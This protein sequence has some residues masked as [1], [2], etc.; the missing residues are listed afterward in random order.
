MDKACLVLLK[1]P[2]L[3]HDHSGG[4][5]YRCVFWSRSRVLPAEKSPK[6]SLLTIKLRFVGH[7]DVFGIKTGIFLEVPSH[8][9]RGKL[10][11]FLFKGGLKS[12][13]YTRASISGWVPELLI[14]AR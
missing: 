6:A 14:A 10:G 4:R 7:A 3:F 9:G 13:I 5:G 1:H 11:W 12:C 2:I 8:R